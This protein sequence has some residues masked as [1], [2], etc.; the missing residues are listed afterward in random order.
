[1]QPKL[2]TQQIAALS[3]TNKYLARELN[4]TKHCAMFDHLK[5]KCI[6][7]KVQFLHV[8]EH[9]TSQTCHVC[10]CLHKTDA[11]TKI[12][13]NCNYKGDRDILGA[14]NI[15]LKAARPVPS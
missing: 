1:M 5:N 10:G 13:P 4:N 3:T 8:T 12:C 9:Y 15:L 11:E 6:E 2:E 14:L 7:R